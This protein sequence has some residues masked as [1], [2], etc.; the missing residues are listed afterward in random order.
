MVS[1]SSLLPDISTVL[2]SPVF[3]VFSS[4]L[5]LLWLL[6]YV[7]IQF[8][9]CAER[10]GL[11]GL[12]VSFTWASGRTQYYRKQLWYWSET[13]RHVI[14]LHLYPGFIIKKSLLS[15][16]PSSRL[17]PQGLCPRLASVGYVCENDLG[18][19]KVILLPHL[20]HEVQRVN[21]GKEFACLG[22][23]EFGFYSEQ[24][25]K[26]LECFKQRNSTL[27]DRIWWI[28]VGSVL[29]LEVSGGS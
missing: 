23:K 1:S 24:I 22:I 13:L 6:G 15:S 12:K 8:T 18:L 3:S 17:P 2:L 19:L 5:E 21:R 16:F 14:E 25:R 4:S 10:A 28:V 26:Q 9:R 7:C 20:V 29:R 27:S 11:F